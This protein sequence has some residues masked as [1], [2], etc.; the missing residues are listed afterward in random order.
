MA[1]NNI[2]DLIN[3]FSDMMGS[4]ENAKQNNAPSFDA[5]KISP[6]MIKNIAGM[7]GRQFCFE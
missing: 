3:K 7:L 1:D 6:D 4:S 2:S 5:S